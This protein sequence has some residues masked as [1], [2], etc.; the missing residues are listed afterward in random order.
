MSYDEIADALEEVTWPRPL[1][2]ILEPAFH[3]FA[4]TN[5]WV[6]DHEPSPK[7]VLRMMVEQAMTFSQFVSHPDIARFEG[8][9]LRYLTDAYRTLRQI[10]P[11]DMRT[12]ELEAVI[13][14]L[15]DLIRTVDSSLLDEWEALSDPKKAAEIAQHRDVVT[16]TD[17]DQER[18]FGSSED[19][20]VSLATNQH[21]FHRIIQ[22]EIFKRVKCFALDDLD[23]L[24][25]EEDW[26]GAED[27]SERRWENTLDRYF[28]E[29]DWLGSGPEAQSNKRY[30]WMPNPMADDLAA[31]RLSD[32]LI[33]ANADLLT[34][35]DTPTGEQRS[36]LITYTMDDELG[37]GDWRFLVL[38]DVAASIES[39]RVS[40]RLLDVGPR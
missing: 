9:L 13:K 14:W 11:D 26:D 16:A 12:D 20:S 35:P 10:V 36:I 17:G 37:D 23:G 4:Q 33:E 40:L 32:R 3:T 19:G 25:K 34:T 5:P 29:Y 31:A 39:N 21:F 30:K 7:F 15:K 22:K 8:I 38:V 1:E 2:E 27:W 28:A 6:G 24:M 18:A